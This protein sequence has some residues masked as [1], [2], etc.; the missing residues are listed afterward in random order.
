MH[1]A[2]AHVRTYPTFDWWKPLNWWVSMYVPNLSAI[3]PIVAELQQ[4]QKSYFWACTWH[5]RTCGFLP[6]L[7]DAKH[8]AVGPLGTYQIWA[9]SAQS[10]L[11]YSEGTIFDTPSIC[12]CHVL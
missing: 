2:R 9:R 1:V 8:S 11:S 3:G 5:V 4:G 10:L 6:L 7:I 12:T